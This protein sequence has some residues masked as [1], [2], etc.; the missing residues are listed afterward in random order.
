MII[1]DSGNVGIGTLNPTSKVHVSGDV[2]LTGG[3]KFHDINSYSW[4]QIGS[5]ISGEVNG[6]CF[7]HSIDINQDGSLL[8]IGAYKNDGTGTEAGQARVYEYNTGSNSW[9]QKGSDIDGEAAG[10]QSGLNVSISKDGN[11]VSSG[12]QYNE[13]GGV[14]AGVIYA[15]HG[16]EPDMNGKL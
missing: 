9:T 1:T 14:N 11:F 8:V 7:G 16:V 2:S 10:D 13:S 6:D 15:G 4:S 12:A 3:V 5:D